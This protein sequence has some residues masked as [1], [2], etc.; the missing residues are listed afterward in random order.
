MSYNIEL[1]SNS[2]IS[3]NLHELVVRNETSC[4]EF[5]YANLSETLSFSEALKSAEVDCLVLYAVNVLK[6]NLGTRR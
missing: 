2:T 3:K 1:C 4:Y 5:F 6:P